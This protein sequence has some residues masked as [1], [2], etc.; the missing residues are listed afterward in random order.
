[1]DQQNGRLSLESMSDMMRRDRAVY[2]RCV[3][4]RALKDGGLV[5]AYYEMLAR[6][7]EYKRSLWFKAIS[8]SDIHQ[9]MIACDW[10]PLE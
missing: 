1:M 9:L 8:Q 4:G 10:Q 5:N 6:A 2:V 7:D 3:R